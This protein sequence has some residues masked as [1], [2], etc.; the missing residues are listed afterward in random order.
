MEVE[1]HL[2]SGEDETRN[3]FSISGDK[4]ALFCISLCLKVIETAF[5]WTNSANN[6]LGQANVFDS[7]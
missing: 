2:E 7:Q 1:K 3:I 6:L 4:D 5:H